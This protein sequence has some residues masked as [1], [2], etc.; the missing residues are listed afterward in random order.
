MNIHEKQQRINLKSV[1]DCWHSLYT[2][3]HICLSC[4]LVSY[5]VKVKYFEDIKK[6]DINIRARTKWISVS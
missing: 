3:K 4:D 5:S 1:S 6:E 2:V